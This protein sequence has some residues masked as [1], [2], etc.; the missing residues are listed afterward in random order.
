MDFYITIS[1]EADLQHP[2]EFSTWNRQRKFTATIPPIDLTKGYSVALTEI[3]ISSEMDIPR[4]AVAT[5]IVNTRSFCGI[6]LPILCCAAPPTGGNYQYVKCIAQG[7]TS[8]EVTFIDLCPSLS[9]TK[10]DPK[11][12][13]YLTLHFKPDIKRH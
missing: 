13:V 10:L 12:F 3:I 8:I 11:P 4:L 2:N 7:Y 6:S 5:N 9:T 1:N